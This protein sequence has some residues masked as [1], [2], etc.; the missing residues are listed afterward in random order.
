MNKA[1]GEVKKVGEIKIGDWIFEKDGY[2]FKVTNIVPMLKGRIALFLEDYGFTKTRTAV[3]PSGNVK[4][5]TQ[6]AVA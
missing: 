5:W 1:N 4:V 6:K 3:F 2:A